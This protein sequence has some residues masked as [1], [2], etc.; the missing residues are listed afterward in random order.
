MVLSCES[1][2]FSLIDKPQIL[3][4]GMALL[5]INCYMKHCKL[6]S[7]SNRNKE[8]IEFVSMLQKL[9]LTLISNFFEMYNI[10]LKS[11]ALVNNYSTFT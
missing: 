10:F 1:V 2:V 11:V 4:E 6:S 9:Y 8:V 7:N 5:T 3:K